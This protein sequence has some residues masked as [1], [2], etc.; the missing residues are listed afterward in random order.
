[1]L[2][3]KFVMKNRKDGFYE[4]GTILLTNSNISLL[5]IEHRQLGYLIN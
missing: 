2:K 5:C 1:M 3:E 4:E